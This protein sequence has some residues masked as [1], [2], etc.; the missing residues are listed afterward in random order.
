MNWTLTSLGDGWIGS[1]PVAVSEP[2]TRVK[3]GVS[4]PRH[5]PRLTLVALAFAAA[6]VLFLPGWARVA[7]SSP[8]C[9]HHATGLDPLLGQWELVA[10]PPTTADAGG[11]RLVGLDFQPH[12]TCWLWTQPPDVVAA[13]ATTAGRQLRTRRAVIV[14]R[15]HA[16]RSALL[17]VP[18]E[19]GSLV[20]RCDPGGGDGDDGGLLQVEGS[21]GERFAGP[22]GEHRMAGFRRL[23]GPTSFHT[24]SGHR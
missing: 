20:V 1:M 10:S 8:V 7:P 2:L 9:P 24:A 12:D 4:R 14:L 17:S 3:A 11:G 18:G 21:P 6:A 13:T 5:P 16:G 19:G 23:T 15:A 22:R